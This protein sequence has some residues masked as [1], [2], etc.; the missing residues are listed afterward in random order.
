MG[1]LTRN[2]EVQA[3]WAPGVKSGSIFVSLFSFGE[4]RCERPEPRKVEAKMVSPSSRC[5]TASR[6][7]NVYGNR[8]SVLYTGLRM[9]K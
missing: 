1:C 6:P 4:R 9:A 8:L 7:Y 2:D 3:M 5:G